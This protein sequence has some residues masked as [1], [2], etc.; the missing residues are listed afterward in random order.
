MAHCCEVT[1]QQQQQHTVAAEMPLHT[2]CACHPAADQAASSK[3]T[4]THTH[5]HP[6]GHAH[7]HKRAVPTPAAIKA[8]PGHKRSGAVASSYCK[9]QAGR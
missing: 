8:A 4:H 1:E 3:H 2:V 7:S 5:T 9:Q 6:T